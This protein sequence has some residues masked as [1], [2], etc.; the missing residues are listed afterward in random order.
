MKQITLIQI[1]QKFILISIVFFYINCEAKGKKPNIN[2]AE[3][4]D[5]VYACWLGKNIGGTLGMPFEGKTDLNNITFYTNIKTGEPTAN[6]DL[7][8]QILWLKAME[9]NNC[10]VDAILLVSIGLNTFLQLLIG[11]NMV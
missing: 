3:F 6:D 1:G 9:E 7:D 11:M 2:N 10:Q 4:R 8:L 5:Q